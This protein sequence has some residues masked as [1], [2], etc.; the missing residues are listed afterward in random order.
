MYPT[1]DARASTSP[2]TTDVGPGRDVEQMRDNLPAVA[3]T[4][5]AQ[6][7]IGEWIDHCTQPPP[8]RV[9]GHVAK[10]IKTM[11][12]EGID[13]ERVRAGLAEWNT[14]GLHP[15][16]LPS[17]V[18]GIGNSRPRTNGRQSETDDIF[19]RA[20]ERAQQREANA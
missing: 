9:K 12:D 8:G 20:M 7:L 1:Q 4:R 5:T 11:L 17:I 18:H 14:K 2:E 15:S 13:Y 19:S 3:D 16:V 6:T 10:E